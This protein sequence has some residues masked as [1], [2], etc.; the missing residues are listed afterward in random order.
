MKQ[1]SLVYEG[2]DPQ[3]EP[4]REALCT[5]GNGCFATRGAA[6]ESQADEAIHYPGTYLAGGYNRLDSQ[7][8]GRTITNE[9]LVNFPNWLF[10]KFRPE[11]GDWFNLM[12]VEILDYRQELDMKGGILNRRV[13]FRDRRGRESTVTSRRIV[14]MGDPHLAA[15]EYAITAENWS[16]RVTVQSALDGSVINAGVAR[17]RELNSTHLQ[18]LDMGEA[19]KDA[20]YLLVDTNQSRIEVAQAARTRVY[21][22]D[23]GIKPK[24]RTFRDVSIIGQELVFEVTQGET[25]TVEKIV[26]LYSSRDWAI[27]EASYEARLALE[28]CGR[29]HELLQSHTR[30]WKSL[31]HKCDVKIKSSNSEQM[32]LRLHIFH[33]LQ[34]VSPNSIGLDVGVPAR[35]L[36][37]EAYRGHIFWDELFILPFYT[38]RLPEITR[39][40]L[41]Y[42]YRRL[43][44]ARCLAA[45]EG[46]H[47]A[48][49]PWQSGTNGREETQVVHLNPRSGTWGLDY[50]HFQRHV[51]IAIAYNTWQYFIVTGDREFMA[52][53]GAEMI[54]EIARFWA[55]VAT[56]NKKTKRFEIHGVMGPD[57]YHEKY[58]DSDEPGVKNNAYTNVMAVWV[59]ERALQVL[60]LLMPDARRELK[61]KLD[62]R[63]DETKRWIDIT[64]KMTIAFHDD[65]IISQF[66]GYED[67]E[68]LDWE[69]Y[70]KK[71]GN[72]ERLD[73]VL[74][75]EGDSP[76]RY[77]VSKQADVL[78]L[79]YLL[80]AT[81]L[82]RLFNQLGYEFDD[83]MIRRNV[84]YYMKRTW[85]GSTLSRVVHASVLDRIDRS[86]AWAMF[87]EALESDIAD[88]QGGTTPEGIHLGAMA[89]TVDIVLRHYAEIDTTGDVIS[90]NPRLPEH[91]HGLH[92]RLR[93]RK[94]WYELDIDDDKFTLS[95][96]EDGPELVTVSVGGKILE[97]KPG[98]SYEFPLRKEVPETLPL[99][100][101]KDGGNAQ[102]CPEQSSPLSTVQKGKG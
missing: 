4:L 96:D 52:L 102:D 55:S 13:H 81:E 85:H 23:K 100:T 45:E 71:Y 49:Y 83:D 28:R 5:L 9:D 33:L 61:E 70:R 64:H 51:N 10:L 77:K 73:R 26:S 97:L 43:D 7:V 86:T 38:L 14:H 2:F 58:P 6:E 34:T 18:T 93:H 82:R 54:V 27:S 101:T 72:I 30:A 35:G 84:E 76:N 20:V 68:E 29:F 32:V 89:G 75:A 46:Y 41:L 11:D 31:W 16:G 1:W 66:E 99:L 15:I 44:V 88:V 79:F 74:K 25:V 48:M 94:Q 60:D 37:G 78:M 19:G 67:L 65:G 95:I 22:G 80:P 36:H 21:R 42:R 47:G 8:A 12:A 50:S 56:D 62:L 53:Y 90:F 87:L 91:L 59:L 3:H 39:N 92:L 40:L 57:E 69:G 98:G 24:R 63:G 17:Y